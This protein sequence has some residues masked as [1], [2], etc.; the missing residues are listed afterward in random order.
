MN[1]PCEQRNLE[2]WTT[3]TEVLATLASIF[4]H[5][6]ITPVTLKMKLF[7][8][9]IMGKGKRRRCK[10]SSEEITTW[11]EIMADL[12]GISSSPRF[13]GNGFS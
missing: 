1:S 3:K 8:K 12:N 9:K 6:G 2:T 10:T 5:L 11:K 13:V 4:D 7:L